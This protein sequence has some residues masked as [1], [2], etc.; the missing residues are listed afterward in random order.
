[1]ANISGLLGTAGGGGGS[2]YAAPSGVTQPQLDTAYNQTQAG[3]QQQQN[4]VNALNGQN[5]LGHQTDVYN[6][7]QNVAAGRGPNPAQAMLAQATGANTAN[8]AALM[9]GQRGATANPGL[10]ARQ[11]AMQ[12]T[13]NQ[14]NAA[15]QGATLQANQSLNAMN[16]LGNLANT[17]VNQQQAGLSNLTG[18]SQA[19]QNALLGIQGNINNANANL[20]GAN[21]SGQQ[22][23]QGGILNSLGSMGGSLF[24]G[25]G[26]LSSS[27]GPTMAG[28]AGDLGSGAGDLT[29]LAA[30]G[31][32]VTRMADG[33]QLDPNQIQVTPITTAPVSNGPQSGF[34]QYLQS[35]NQQQDMPL[36]EHKSSGGGNPLSGVT[37]LVGPA[38]QKAATW[39]TKEA[40]PAIGDFFG[41]MATT[42]G[43]ASGAV[44]GGAADV[45]VDAAPAVLAAAK[46]GKVPALVSP[47]EQYLPPEDVEK[48]KKGANPMEVGQKVPGKPKVGGA[49]NSYANDTVKANLD[50]GGIVIPRSV[51]QGE[52]PHWA[53]MKFV[54][55]TMKKNR[56]K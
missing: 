14:Q 41:G 51:T 22:G 12:G 37:S 54:H 46:G 19:Q 28:G 44:A 39:G 27:A 5:G 45:G 30:K 15:G 8:Q 33:G 29:A 2:G 47:G 23:L 16:Q 40:L 6:Q 50:E 17:Q 24:G 49:K 31:G 48:V 32:R 1:M 42:A 3:I 18:A 25:G 35:Q 21:M 7:I 13:A 34:G 55:A 52:N 38:L 11:A 56:H 36:A 53:A 43:G 10:I 4:F 26:G 9:A 20:I